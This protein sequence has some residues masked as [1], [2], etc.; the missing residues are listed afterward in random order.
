MSHSPQQCCGEYYITNI[1]MSEIRFTPPAILI[2]NRTEMMIN[3]KKRYLWIAILLLIFLNMG[4][5]PNS[6]RCQPRP[7]NSLKDR[8]FSKYQN[9]A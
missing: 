2:K 3:V 7:F 6:G 8:K 4:L 1:S 9:V 5:E